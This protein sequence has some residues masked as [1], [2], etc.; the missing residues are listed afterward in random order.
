MKTDINKKTGVRI[1]DI[2]FTRSGDKGDTSNIGVIAFDSEKYELLKKHLTPDYIKEIFKDVCKG[3]V[4]RYNLDNLFALNFLLEESLGGG[5]ARS[6]SSDP[7]GK[8]YAQ[9]LLTY[10]L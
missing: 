1:S 7:Q 8:L 6:L 5:G 3:K 9:R 4:I 2:A 10:Y